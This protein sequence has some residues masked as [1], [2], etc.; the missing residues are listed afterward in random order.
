MKRRWLSIWATLY[1]GIMFVVAGTGKIFAS[2]NIEPLRLPEYLPLPLA[3]VISLTLPYVEIIIGS[4]LILG[5]AVKAITSVSTLLI[6]GFIA[7]NLVFIYFGLANYPCGCF[8][9]A[10]GG[11]LS[12]RTSLMLDGVMAIMVAIVFLFYP[13]GFRSIKPWCLISIPESAGGISTLKGGLV[14]EQSP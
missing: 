13:G 9:G 14:N 10:L 7:S 4:L 3:Q 11:G 6:V 2:S 5:I 12:I 1:L 8:G